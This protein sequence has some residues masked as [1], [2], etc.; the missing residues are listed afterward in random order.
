[1]ILIK[2]KSVV[3]PILE[4]TII[5]LHLQPAQ[6]MDEL[7]KLFRLRQEKNTKSQ[8]GS[9]ES[10]YLDVTER[11]IGRSCDYETQ[12]KGYSGKQGTHTIKDS[13]I[14]DEWQF[15]HFAG[16]TFRGA[17]HDKK[18]VTIELP[19][20]SALSK[21]SLFFS[22]DKAY[23]KYEPEGVQCLAPFKATRNNP[24]N[25]V[26]IKFKLKTSKKVTTH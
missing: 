25:N 8:C 19:N 13:V 11:R 3:E 17:I 12:A 1:L 24:L 14:N 18:M 26:Q 6:T 5:D 10:L 7:I 15:I 2:D 23:Q 16:Q 21:W 9:V 4:Q 20:L 22:K